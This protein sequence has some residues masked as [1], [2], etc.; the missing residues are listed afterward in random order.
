[1]KIRVI[2]LNK[3]VAVVYPAPKSRKKGETE[4]AWLDRVFAKAMQG[5][6]KGFP[7]KDM[8]SSELPTRDKRSAWEMKDGKVVVNKS[9]V[10]DLNYER[11]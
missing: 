5:K 10:I 1:M 11:A 4:E 9:I 7:Y 6:Y 2:E 3:S 8:D